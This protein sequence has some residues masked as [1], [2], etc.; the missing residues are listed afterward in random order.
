MEGFAGWKWEGRH[1][2]AVAPVGQ[3]GMVRNLA[4]SGH[5]YEE[6]I[7]WDLAMWCYSWGLAG[8]VAP[9]DRIEMAHPAYRAE[10]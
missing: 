9:V 7:A 2:S 6:S 1:T 5:D 4:Q 10:W 3:S 8:C